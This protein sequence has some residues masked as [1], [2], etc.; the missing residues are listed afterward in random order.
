MTATEPLPMP[1]SSAQQHSDQLLKLIQQQIV[2]SGGKITFA[3]YMHLCLYAPGLGYYSA[4]S[5]K[6]GQ[7]GDFTTAPE[8]SPLFSRTLAHHIKDVFQQLEQPN[9]IEFGAGSG[10]MATDILIELAHIQCLPAQYFI[11]ETSADLR[12]RQQLK[13]AQLIPHLAD[14]VCWLNE[15]PHHFVGVMLANEVCDAMP[16]HCLKFSDGNVNE[17][18]IEQHQSVLQWCEGKLSHPLLATRAAEIKSFIGNIDYVT[19]VNLAAEA[20]IA[21]LADALQQGAVFVI[22]Y[23]HPKHSYYHLQRSNGTLMCYYQ[24]QGHDNPLILQGLQD[25]TAHIDFTALAQSAADNDLDVAGFQSQADFL[26]AGGITELVQQDGNTN[27][28]LMLQQASEIKRLTLPS[29]MGEN[30][31]VLALS[32]NLAHLLPRIQ[33]RDQRYKL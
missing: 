11:I 8:I 32:R 1:D 27:E 19:E 6:L 28:L 14:R 23:G 30:F 22:D 18:Y 7:H 10:K 26:I 15:L 20:W 4:G 2:A 21:S 24:H 33:L 16:V 3:D 13:I 12:E 31:K 17:L 9:I 29:E 5:E 25:I